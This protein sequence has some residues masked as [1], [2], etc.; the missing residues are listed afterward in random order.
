MK[1]KRSF[2]VVI[3]L[4]L[5]QLFFFSSCRV[6]DDVWDNGLVVGYILRY[7]T[8]D[9]KKRSRNTCHTYTCSPY[10]V[11]DSEEGRLKIFAMRFAKN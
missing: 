2:L 6:R 8:S 4:T 9:I 3:I 7:K 5:F 1:D 10:V 11:R